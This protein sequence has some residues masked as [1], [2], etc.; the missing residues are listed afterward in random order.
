MKFMDKNKNFI[1]VA[2]DFEIFI[3]KN[4]TTTEIQK[5]GREQ[6]ISDEKRAR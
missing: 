5:C 6:A 4:Q 3:R 1:K 2:D